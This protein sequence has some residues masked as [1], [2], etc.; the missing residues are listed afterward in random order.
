MECFGSEQD[1]LVK[2]AHESGEEHKALERTTIWLAVS[3][4]A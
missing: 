1:E 2:L 4:Q 3:R